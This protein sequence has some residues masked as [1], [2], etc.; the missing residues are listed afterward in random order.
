MNTGASQVFIEGSPLVPF[1]FLFGQAKRNKVAP[2]KHHQSKPEKLHE[3]G[4]NF[5]KKHLDTHG[6]VDVSYWSPC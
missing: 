6:G 3:N 4:Q 5:L 1:W 2:I